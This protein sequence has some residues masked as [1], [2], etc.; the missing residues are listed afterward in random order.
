[1][2]QIKVITDDGQAPMLNDDEEPSDFDEQG[3]R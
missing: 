2:L 3:E 1:L